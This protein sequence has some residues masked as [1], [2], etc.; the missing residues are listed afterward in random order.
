MFGG[1]TLMVGFVLA[2]LL[3]SSPHALAQEAEKTTSGPLRT[4]DQGLQSHGIALDEVSVLQALQNSEAEIRWLAAEKLGN[5]ND[6]SAIPQIESALLHE[7]NTRAKINIA[8][9]L[10]EL[11]SRKGLEGLTAVCQD[12]HVPIYM[13]LDAVRHLQTF[14][15]Q[16][17]LAAIIDGLRLGSESDPAIRLQSL[18]LLSQ[19]PTA[20]GPYLQGARPL[21][22]RE[23]MDLN[24]AVRAEASR[25]LAQIGDSSSL[26]ALREAYSLEKDESIRSI[27]QRCID[28]LERKLLS[29][30]R[31]VN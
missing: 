13:R 7:T 1:I 14:H 20:D 23:L 21:V 12:P 27:M 17:C 4:A 18:S 30:V 11:D 5:D 24:P 8:T 9:A 25:S 29:D 28:I 15:A 31:V 19:F 2:H 26:S 10:A 3:F 22:T 6:R 16:G